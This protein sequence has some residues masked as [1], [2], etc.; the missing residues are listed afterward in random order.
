MDNNVLDLIEE[1]ITNSVT[2]YYEESKRLLKDA[3]LAMEYTSDMVI[4]QISRVNARHVVID[5][6]YMIRTELIE[7]YREIDDEKK[8][9][10]LVKE[11]EAV[12]KVI[13]SLKER[14]ASIDS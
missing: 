6:L 5:M 12:E 1:G 8:K 4:R 7:S 2:S 14:R 10:E 3:D 13:L 11:M 9:H